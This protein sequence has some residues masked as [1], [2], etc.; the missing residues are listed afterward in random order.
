MGLSGLVQ[1]RIATG[2]GCLQ[3]GRISRRPRPIRS[4]TQQAPRNPPRRM[5]ENDAG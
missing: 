4:A 5:A 1:A 3:K 2:I